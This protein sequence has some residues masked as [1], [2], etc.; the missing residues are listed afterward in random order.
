MTVMT[1]GFLLP[2]TDVPKYFTRIG[3]L[4]VANVFA[5]K[6]FISILDMEG[7]CRHM[8]KCMYRSLSQ[9]LV[10][11]SEYLVMGGTFEHMG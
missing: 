8:I 7:S 11:R 6:M 9:K 5:N 1:D 10:W 3:T 2:E 4:L